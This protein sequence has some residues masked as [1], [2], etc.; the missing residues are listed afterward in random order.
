MTFPR[1]L[2]FAAMVLL[3]APLGC[4]EAQ[5]QYPASTPALVFPSRAEIAQ[6]PAKAPAPELFGSKDVAVDEWT[7]ESPPLPSDAPYDD[8]S[9]W[10]TLL[11][12]LTKTRGDSV[13][14]SPAMRCAA[15]EIGRFY[16]SNHALPVERL[17]RF[18]LARC[19]GDTTNLNP[20]VWF[21]EAPASV[22][23]DVVA[24][25]ARD[26]LANAIEE[27][28][29]HG[30]HL[31]GLA[32]ARDAKH[33]AVVFAIAADEARL[34]PTTKQIDASR[35]VTIRGAARGDYAQITGFVNRGD[36]AVSP[37]VSDPAVRAP[38]FAISC[39]VAT[40]D[41]FDWIEVLGQKRG[42]VMLHVISDVL[43]YD[44]DGSA[45][46]YKAKSYGPASPV[47][48][49]PDFA[50]V[51]LSRINDVRKA[52]K[53]GA[54]TLAP[55][56]SIENERLTGTLL[57]S[58]LGQG[59]DSADK[60]AIGLLA[61][62]DVEGGTI[63]D[64]HFFIGA[65]A[66]THDATTW[67]EFAVER[68][69]GRMT[70]LDPDARVIAIGPAVLA[71]ASGLGAAVTTYALFDS[72]DHTADSTLFFRRVAEA[73]E[74]L[75]LP[76]PRRIAAPDEMKKLTARVL[77]E[78]TTP[79]GAL[80]AMLA[81][82]AWQSGRTT[83]GYVLE[84]NRVGAVD[85]PDVFLKAGPLSMA[86]TVTHHRAPGAAWG[87]YVIFTLMPGSAPTPTTEA[88]GAGRARRA[89]YGPTH[90]AM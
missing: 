89:L 46:R 50:R 62:W 45:V 87:Q 1:S 49:E 72:D 36:Y 40:G 9:P 14:L 39:E 73:R 74:E 23:D 71:G 28:L 25:K 55:K 6:I 11:R 7:I 41:S 33:V 32:L 60:A 24:A 43:A 67:L 18:I 85:I 83:L 58:A 4:A 88:K 53:L 59:D 3:I 19:G 80:H 61:G 12:D 17:R 22:S 26:V 21:A 79:Q 35:H 82:A 78:E 76:A 37:C 27:P 77:R 68:P 15:A 63:K 64:G 34:E 44:G 70:I 54:L 47:A 2:S 52:A 75:G 84:T 81:S 13:S 5:P 38:R 30:H 29:A 8:P 56:Q 31:A 16:I 10:G 69:I 20:Y 86:V 90:S 48:S 65:V 42:R 57:D 51:L 66:P